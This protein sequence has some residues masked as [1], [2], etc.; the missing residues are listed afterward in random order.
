MKF[1]NGVKLNTRIGEDLVAVR[2]RTG[3]KHRQECLCHIGGNFYLYFC[4]KDRRRHRQECL[5]YNWGCEYVWGLMGS[6][7]GKWEG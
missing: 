3:E 5:C 4:M 7:V 6:F 2:A 1:Y